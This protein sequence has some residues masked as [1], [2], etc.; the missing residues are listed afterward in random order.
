MCDSPLISKA[1]LV[2][3]YQNSASCKETHVTCSFNRP[4]QGQSLLQHVYL[5]NRRFY[6]QDSVHQEYKG[7]K[8]SLDES[9][10]I[11]IKMQQ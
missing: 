8:D 10:R 7:E 4:E 5:Q 3:D 2:N 9:D 6:K 11:P 1:D